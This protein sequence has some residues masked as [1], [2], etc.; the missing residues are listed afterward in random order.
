VTLGKFLRTSKMAGSNLASGGSGAARDVQEVVAAFREIIAGRGCANDGEVY[1]NVVW[2]LREL[3]ARAAGPEVDASLVT[4]ALVRAAARDGP[5][6]VTV[7]GGAGAV[8]DCVVSFWPRALGARIVP[9]EC[10]CLCLLWL[11]C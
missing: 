8:C 3:D 5:A 6:R 1:S 4:R 7:P 10:V 2:R 11:W 9:R